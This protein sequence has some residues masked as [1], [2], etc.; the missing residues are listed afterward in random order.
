[1]F[2]LVCR[3]TSTGETKREERD[4][5]FFLCKRLNGQSIRGAP[6]RL[7]RFLGLHEY[8]QVSGVRVATPKLELYVISTSK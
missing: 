2:W 1:M 3:L 4:T 5:A 8:R 7:S 6:R